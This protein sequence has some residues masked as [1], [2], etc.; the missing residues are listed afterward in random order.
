MSNEAITL[1]RKVRGISSGARHQL[2]LLADHANKDWRCWP[3]QRSIADDQGVTIKTVQRNNE[4]LERAGL[5][6][7][8]RRGKPGGGRFTDRYQLNRNA[9]ELAAKPQEAKTGKHDADQRRQD[10]S[11]G[12]RRHLGQAK[13]TFVSR[14]IIEPKDN[15]QACLPGEMI[16]GDDSLLT[17]EANDHTAVGPP[18]EDE[19]DAVAP[20][21]DVLSAYE[22]VWIAPNAVPFKGLGLRRLFRPPAKRPDDLAVAKYFARWYAEPTELAASSEDYNGQ[23]LDNL[24]RGLDSTRRLRSR[25]RDTLVWPTTIST[26]AQHVRGAKSN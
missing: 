22:A 16:P 1:A 26:T 15:P 19:A 12:Q 23:M 17:E 5:I 8:Q 11:F 7:R 25:D 9:M 4:R 14:S 21:L 6:T 20:D 18:D 3:S 2:L 24:E 10:V 13:A